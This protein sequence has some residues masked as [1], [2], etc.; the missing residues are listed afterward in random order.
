MNPSE[1][2]FSQSPSFSRSP[3]KF[4]CGELG[5]EGDRKNI[6]IIKKDSNRYG[7]VIQQENN[8]I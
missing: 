6:G 1:C 5:G 7:Q 8:T 4:I 2:I 3:Q